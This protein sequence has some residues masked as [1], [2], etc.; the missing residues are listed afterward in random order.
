M[1][2]RAWKYGVADESG[3]IV[4]LR[5]NLLGCYRVIAAALDE[6]ITA[7]EL[8]ALQEASDTPMVVSGNV[9]GHFT[10]YTIVDYADIEKVTA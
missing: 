9:G 4:S 1:E 3:N 7:A 5:T 2:S 6:N 8:R 10:T